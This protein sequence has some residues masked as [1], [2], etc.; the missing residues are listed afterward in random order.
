ME[1]PPLLG[2][3]SNFTEAGGRC[4]KGC[5]GRAAFTWSTSL[6]IRPAYR[7]AQ[8]STPWRPASQLEHGRQL[9]EG[10][11]QSRCWFSAASQAPSTRAHILATSVPAQRR[12]T[13]GPSAR[14]N[15][16]HSNPVGNMRE[17]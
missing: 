11:L 2:P 15:C 12:E 16:F 14:P 8:S 13:N 6:R 1:P 3:P 7:L 5:Q 10:A 4:R 17:G 9:R